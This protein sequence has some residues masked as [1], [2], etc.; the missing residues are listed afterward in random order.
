MLDSSDALWFIETWKL[1]VWILPRACVV[2][3]C[4]CVVLGCISAIFIIADNVIA[5]I[6]AIIGLGFMIGISYIWV[7]MLKANIA[8][9]QQS[10]QRVKVTL[11]EVEDS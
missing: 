3:G 2:T 4:A 1:Y 8:R 5:S 9:K 11:L 6:V 7:V 10:V